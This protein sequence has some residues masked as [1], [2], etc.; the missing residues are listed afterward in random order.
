MTLAAATLPPGQPDPT[1]VRR[2]LLSQRLFL[3]L[4]GIAACESIAAWLIPQLRADLPEWLPTLS[5][6]IALSALLCTLSLLFSE[7]RYSRT[8]LSIS[9]LLALLPVVLNLTILLANIGHLP[10]VP[11]GFPASAPETLMVGSGTLQ[12]ILAFFVISVAMLILL[13]RWTWHGASADVIVGILCFVAF[14][15]IAQSLFGFAGLFG[16]TRQNLIHPLTL[17]CI[18]MLTAVVALRQAEFGIFSIFLGSGIGSRIAR[19]F[20]PVLLVWP[21]VREVLE[22]QSGFRHL[23][24]EHFAAAILTAL[25]LCIALAFLMLVVW[26]INDMEKEIHDLT[27]RDELT[28][29]YNMRGFYLLAEQTLRLAQRSKQPFS[30]LFLDLDGLK[31]INDQQGHQ[32]GSTYLAETGEILQ[33]TFRDADVKGRFGGDEF[34][35]AGQFTM[36]GIEIAAQ[37]LTAAAEERNAN[38]D[39]RFPLSFSIGYVTSDYYSTESLKELV[40][41]ADE[42]MYK[43]KRR[44]KAQR[45]S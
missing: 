26:R 3:V 19:G 4:V 21:F 28:G 27:L 17:L 39:R 29:L 33:A 16:L 15:L 12:G 8:L 41:R 34:V 7:A 5:G 37:R 11:I 18:V 45:V 13:F 24:P 40:T 2:M 1:W 36:V 10:A 22:A 6:P 43:D 14:V 25:A 35:V 9:R 44:R 23:L 30:V 32:M 42:A 38:G 20:A 31:Q